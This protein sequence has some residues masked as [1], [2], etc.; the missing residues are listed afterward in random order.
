MQL[1]AGSQEMSLFLKIALTGVAVVF[2]SGT[3]MLMV[4][5][6]LRL[7]RFNNQRE[8]A[9]RLANI[10]NVN[11]V[12]QLAVESPETLL[13]FQ[14]FLNGVPLIELPPA[15]AAPVSA[16]YTAPSSNGHNRQAEPLPTSAG[17]DLI[18]QAKAVSATAGTAASLL[19][20]LGSILPGSAGKAL[21][22]Q[23]SAARGLQTKSSGAAHAPEEAQRKMDALQ[24][25][26]LRLAGQPPPQATGAMPSEPPRQVSV[27]VEEPVVDVPVPQANPG[28]QR[29]AS[30]PRCAACFQT[31]AIGPGES[32]ALTLRIS[33]TKWLFK[34]GSYLYTLTCQ[35]VALQKLNK[36]ASPLTRQGIA[37][38]KP[39]EAWRFWLRLALSALITVSCLA[40]LFFFVSN[41]WG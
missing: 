2:L 18:G 20:T 35:Q 27:A 12:Y 23:S 25:D 19:G 22:A 16:A 37:H 3:A 39:M 8:H 4:L 1:F 30:L 11:S 21:K 34:E 14:L 40:A 5:G 29:A 17:S 6:V 24:R 38:L 32:I 10:G 13:K 31:G 28:L 7:L 15:P 9:I 26:S 33:P 36:E 41:I